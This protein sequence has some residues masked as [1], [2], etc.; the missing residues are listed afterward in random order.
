MRSKLVALV[1]LVCLL[2]AVAMWLGHEGMAQDQDI[3]EETNDAP[4]FVMPQSGPFSPET[5]AV[6]QSAAI[7]A[8]A[9][10][11]HADAS[12]LAFSYW[13]AAGAI[14]PAC[15]VCHAGTGFRAF[16]G[17]DGGDARPAAG[18]G[19][20]RQRRRLPDLPQSGSCRGDADRT[21]QRAEPSG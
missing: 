6:P 13:N 17:L 11:G 2:P 12:A 1:A 9:R 10:S 21:S 4:I 16:H 15:A 3:A 18:T 8:W 20:H 5:I 7:T 19:S 14:P